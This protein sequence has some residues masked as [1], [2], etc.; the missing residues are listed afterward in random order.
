MDQSS[1]S[2]YY[3]SYCGEVYFVRH[4]DEKIP[5][6][7]SKCKNMLFLFDF[8]STWSIFYLL[9]FPF[10]KGQCR[11]RNRTSDKNSNKIT[12]VSNG[13]TLTNFTNTCESIF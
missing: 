13:H 7:D 3:I 9:G 4:T 8:V 11:N 5:N 2:F 10:A 1:L 6:Y 12:I